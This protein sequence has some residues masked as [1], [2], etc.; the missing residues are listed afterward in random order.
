MAKVTGKVYKVYCKAFN[1][2]NSYS[3]K[4]DGNDVYYR[5]N[6]KNPGDIE[7]K[8]VEFEA[9]DVNDA[10]NAAYINGK[11]TIVD[12]S[13]PSKPAGSSGGGSWGSKNE[14]AIHYQNAAG[15]AIPMVD[16]LIRNGAIKLPAKTAA[17]AEVIEAAVDH[18]TAQ[19][20]EDI[21]TFGAVSRAN[22][23]GAEAAAPEKPG[24]P[25]VD[26]DE[27]D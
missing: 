16:L 3:V 19:F 18:Y 26:E 7:G 14:P 6:N 25:A 23:E 24:K 10:G 8:T 12:T 11:I 13:G 1:G 17:I 2:K 21:T 27:D 20:F 22:G 15:R 9:G 4:L 5:N